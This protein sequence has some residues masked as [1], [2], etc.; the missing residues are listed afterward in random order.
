MT[1]SRTV[2]GIPASPGIVIGKAF[3]LSKPD[4]PVTHAIV[5]SRGIEAEVERF[6]AACQVAREHTKQLRAQVAAR[7]GPVQAKIFDPQ[8]LMLEDPALI[9]ATITYIRDSRLT[10]ERA[11]YLRVLEFRAQWLEMTHARMMDRVADLADIEARLLASLV[12]MSP[13]NS[14]SALPDHPVIVIAKELTPSRTIEL[15]PQ[16]VLGIATDAGTR[17]SHSSILARSLGMPA[18]VGLGDLFQTVEAGEELILDGHRGRVVVR[19]T[20]AEKGKFHDRDLQVREMAKEVAELATLEPVT[21]D[22]VK[23]EL[24]ANLEF[25]EDA[26]MAVTA[27]ADGVGL[28]RTEFLVV[29]VSTVPTEEEQYKAFKKVVEAFA[30][31]PVTIRTYDLGGDKYPAFMPLLVEDNPFLGWRG[32]R[33]YDKMPELFHNQVRAVLRSAVHGRVQMLLPMVNSVEEVEGV[34][35]IMRR[36]LEELAAEGI[37]HANCLLGIMLETPAA[38]ST[39]EVL[40]RHV[41]FF[42]LGTNDLA[43][44][45]LAVDRG[46]AQLSRFYDF[47]H[48]AL[49]R[50]IREA[51]KGAE[52]VGRPLSACG[53]AASDVAGAAL[54][55]GLGVRSLSC[56]PGAFP[57]IKKLIR[58]V[59]A[60]QLERIVRGLFSEETGR[61][62]RARLL[63]SLQECIDTFEVAA[64]AS[65]SHPE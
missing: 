6:K 53:E 35:S 42:S 22:G 62:V 61:G 58:S 31:R 36:A 23:I 55:L 8:L 50:F 1:A 2:Q 10:A 32:V 21:P 15:D 60:N 37:E 41:D 16:R 33:I 26:E 65:L 30:P 51:V 18:V 17:T 28:F 52:R 54:L 19:P 4:F 24:H 9:E 20:Q 38:I 47:Y 25:P 3:L 49:L 12:E 39:I 34:R 44:Y 57:E 14:T 13:P 64:A 48:P 40:G 59:G 56:P 46:N 29:G 43:Q 7:L 63:S 11:V 27:G 45:A 5:P